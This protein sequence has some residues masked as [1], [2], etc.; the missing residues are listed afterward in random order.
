MSSPLRPMSGANSP[1]LLLEKCM[2][3]LGSVNF[4][5]ANLSLGWF[6]LS[7]LLQTI[8]KVIINRSWL[9]PMSAPQKLF[10]LW[11]FAPDQ[12][13]F[14]TKMSSIWLWCLP[15]G[16]CHVYLLD[17]LCGRIASVFVSIKVLKVANSKSLIS[18]DIAVGSTNL[19]LS[20]SPPPPPIT[21]ACESFH[22]FKC[23]KHQ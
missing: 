16:L 4:S 1:L 8:S 12:K 14:L 15:P 13:G 6:W 10:V 17:C 18:F 23:H 7:H 11:A 22:F 20:L 21:S 9:L 5:R 19:S 2:P 3:H